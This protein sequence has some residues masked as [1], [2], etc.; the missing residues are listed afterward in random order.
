MVFTA[1]LLPV[2]VR[3]ESGETEKALENLNVA[4]TNF[5]EMGMDYWLAKTQE[6]LARL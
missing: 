2:G 1:L 3:G 6:V 5:R 4:E